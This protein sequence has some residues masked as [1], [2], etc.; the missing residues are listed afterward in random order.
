MAQIKPGPAFGRVLNSKGF[1]FADAN[2]EVLPAMPVVPGTSLDT[3][4]PSGTMPPEL[5]GLLP[6]LLE[7]G[8]NNVNPEYDPMEAFSNPV[9]PAIGPYPATASLGL[10]ADGHARYLPPAIG[11]GTFGP[12]PAPA[13]LPIGNNP[14][15]GGFTPRRPYQ[16]FTRLYPGRPA[17][18]PLP[19]APLPGLRN[20]N[21]A[22]KTA[23]SLLPLALLF[24]GSRLLGN[25]AAPVLSGVKRGGQGRDLQQYQDAYTQYQN[26]GAQATFQNARQNQ[27]YEDMVKEYEDAQGQNTQE[28]QLIQEGNQDAATQDRL[29]IA[30]QNQTEDNRRLAE[31]AKVDERTAEAKQ[32]LGEVRALLSASKDKY[33]TPAAKSAITRRAVEMSGAGVELPD[34]IYASMAPEDVEELRFKI[35]KEQQSNWRTQVMAG[36]QNARAILNTTFD[37]EKTQADIGLKVAMANQAARSDMMSKILTTKFSADSPNGQQARL[38]QEQLSQLS[39]ERRNAD[40]AKNSAIQAIAKL[41]VSPETTQ[42]RLR[43]GSIVDAGSRRIESADAQ[44][45]TVNAAIQDLFDKGAAE[46]GMITEE[47]R[48]KIDMV[49]QIAPPPVQFSYPSLPDVP[50]PPPAIE[51]PTAGTQGGLPRP[52]WVP[53]PVTN[54]TPPPPRISGPIGMPANGYTLSGGVVVDR[55][56]N[57]VLGRVEGNVFRPIDSYD[58]RNRSGGTVTPKRYAPPVAPATRK[59][60]PATSTRM[61]P[62]KVIGAGKPPPAPRK[63]SS[64]RIK[65]LG[66]SE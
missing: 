38:L 20:E 57:A 9:E 45:A 40:E 61:A 65:Y 37:Q 19:N 32:K 64:S 48:R 12:T 11:T 1:N 26:Q 4:L 6:W 50:T 16:D 34:D 15:P 22:L 31:K 59:A 18:M 25:V 7:G 8:I 49:P 36:S 53:D 56:S 30:L 47:D 54:R 17:P 14:A 21:N 3:A 58:P 62:V 27:S 23:I 55:N 5:S 63:K 60:I 29:N 33:L 51:P 66:V 2:Q 39:T 13:T 44:L 35:W 24:G 43:L 28:N 52:A 41:G 10:P 46:G 42:E